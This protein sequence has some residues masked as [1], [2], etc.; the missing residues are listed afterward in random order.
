MKARDKYLIADAR[1]PLISTDKLW[2]EMLLYNIREQ[3]AEQLKRTFWEITGKEICESSLLQELSGGQ[4]VILMAL[5]ALLSP[6]SRIVFIEL[7][8]SLDAPKLARLKQ[9]IV[10]SE[11][12]V[13][14]SA[15][16]AEDR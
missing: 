16:N 2:D 6:A 1:H 5:L 11:K 15:D 13:I 12:E 7:E 4:K 3:N 8:L 9:E 14:L 10:Q